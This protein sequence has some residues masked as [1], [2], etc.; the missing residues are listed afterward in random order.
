MFSDCDRG[1]GLALRPMVL[2]LPI[3]TLSCAPAHDPCRET[4]NQ[5]NRSVA[6]MRASPETR[7]KFRL[8]PIQPPADSDIEWYHEHCDEGKRRNSAIDSTRENR[9]EP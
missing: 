8:Q 3:L 2:L 1:V 7:A 9:S 5:V 4:A 6:Y